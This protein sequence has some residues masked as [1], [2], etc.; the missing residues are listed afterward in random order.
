[1]IV[2]GQ[3]QGENMKRLILVASIAAFAALPSAAQEGQAP[4]AAPTAACTVPTPPAPYVPAALP[5][6]PTPPKCLNLKTNITTCSDRVFNEWNA[7]MK[8]VNDA[9]RA[10]VNE[11]NA[12]N[13]EIAKY[14]HAATDYAQCEQDRVS[15]FFPED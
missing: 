1:M 3:T 10:R 9:K 5:A 15:K 2:F 11:M 12:Y 8:V 7:K 6:E 14:Q 4:A 13:R